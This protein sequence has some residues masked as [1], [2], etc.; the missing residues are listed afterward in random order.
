MKVRVGGIKSRPEL[1][2]QWGT[3]VENEDGG[4]YG[5]QLKDS[6]IVYGTAK[7]FGGKK[8]E[9][10]DE[11]TEL[12]KKEQELFWGGD[13][14]T[15]PLKLMKTKQEWRICR[16]CCCNNHYYVT[17]C[18][19]GCEFSPYFHHCC[20][21]RDGQACVP[22]DDAKSVPSAC[23]CNPCWFLP[24]C[25]LYPKIACMPTPKT[26]YDLSDEEAEARFGAK[27]DMCMWGSTC[28]CCCS[29]NIYCT[30]C[31]CGC[32]GAGEVHCGCCG[33]DCAFPCDNDVAPYMCGDCCI[34][35]LPKFGCCPKLEDLYPCEESSDT[36]VAAPLQHQDHVKGAA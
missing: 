24:G 4:R 1:N 35:C 20:C 10:P 14:L 31:I 5:V 22:E 34:I 30:S 36:I 27:A 2:G 13:D 26:L 7:E 6:S 3:V 12:V 28:C 25:Y 8:I 21:V 11:K 19:H 29:Q 33:N 17:P 32:D 16:G 9:M 15:L 23:A 18:Q